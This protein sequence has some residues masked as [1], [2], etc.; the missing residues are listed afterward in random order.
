MNLKSVFFLTI[1]L[2]VKAYLISQ[3]TCSNFSTY[4]GGNQFD[5]INQTHKSRSK[6]KSQKDKL[7]RNQSAEALIK[8]NMK[9]NKSM[10]SFG[11]TLI[12][13]KL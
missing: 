2:L 6:S 1:F 4:F 7:S 13:I 8:A 3:Q 10:G 11:D 9:K 5:E 12:N